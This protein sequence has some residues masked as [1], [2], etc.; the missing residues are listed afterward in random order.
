VTVK[1]PPHAESSS[2]CSMNV[3]VGTGNRDDQ[4]RSSRKF[5][6]VLKDVCR[7][8]GETLLAIGLICA[9]KRFVA[10]WI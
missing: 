6:K 3:L 4:V 2:I 1:P 9:R 7:M 10:A 5:F 8:E